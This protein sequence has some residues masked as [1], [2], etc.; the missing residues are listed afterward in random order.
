MP[1][2]SMHVLQEEWAV[3]LLVPLGM[4]AASMLSAPH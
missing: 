1:L 3:W 4:L 2:Y